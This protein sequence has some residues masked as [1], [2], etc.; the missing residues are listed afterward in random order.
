M[1]KKPV[2]KAA[3][4]AAAASKKKDVK[5]GDPMKTF[6][7]MKDCM[8][9]LDDELRKFLDEEVK[10]SARRSRV[11][12]QDIRKAAAV[13]RKEIQAVLISRRGK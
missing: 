2:K 8:T 12:A 9:I 1:A 10:A 7:T 11:A 6:N 4:K 13:I 3:A 5:L